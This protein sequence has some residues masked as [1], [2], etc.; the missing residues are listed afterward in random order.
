MIIIKQAAPK[1]FPFSNDVNFANLNSSGLMIEHGVD[2]PAEKDKLLKTHPFLRPDS[3]GRLPPYMRWMWNPRTGEMLIN[4]GAGMHADMLANYNRKQKEAGKPIS[5]FNSWLRGFYVPK[6]ND[7]AVRPYYMAQE[8]LPFAV[9]RQQDYAPGLTIEEQ[10]VND[11]M[12]HRIKSLVEKG[13]GK[14]IPKKN[15]HT[16]VDNQWLADNYS[17]IGGT[18]W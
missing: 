1:R 13:M 2:T 14:P 9:Q 5:D 12:Q 11:D 3:N 10:S 18:R 15:F 16:N 7:F 4:T 17:D 8:R 6:T